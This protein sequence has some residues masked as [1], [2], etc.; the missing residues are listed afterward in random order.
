MKPNRQFLIDQ[1]ATILRKPTAKPLVTPAEAIAIALS[2]VRW[3]PGGLLDPDGVIVHLVLKAIRQAG[4][5]IVAM[6]RA[7]YES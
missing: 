1:V 7:D 4:W 3:K 6:E 2:T 5:K